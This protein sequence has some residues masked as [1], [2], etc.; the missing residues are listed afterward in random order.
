M[1]HMANHAS[2][3]YLGKPKRKEAKESYQPKWAP[4]DECRRLLQGFMR[5]YDIEG[6]SA[7]SRVLGAPLRQCFRWLTP[8]EASES[9]VATMSSLYL[10][11]LAWIIKNVEPDNPLM[12]QIK[13]GGFWEKLAN[14]K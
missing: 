1:E 7:V 2:P 4:R 10:F 3:V 12:E 11:R 13:K 5:E 8:L 6:A 9:K 14:A